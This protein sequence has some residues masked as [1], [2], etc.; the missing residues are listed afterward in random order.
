MSN[1]QTTRP[2]RKR[3]RWIAL[4]TLGVAGAIGGWY[5]VRHNNTAD[6]QTQLAAAAKAAQAGA[7]SASDYDRRV[8][9]YV[10]DNDPVSREDLGN[11]LI[12]RRGPE[13]L[14]ALIN[15]RIIETAAKERGVDAT[16]AEIETAL[17]ESITSLNVNR[18]R[19]VKE[20]LRTYRKSLFEWKEDVLRTKI[21]LSKMV[22]DRI[23]VSE[24]EMKLAFEALY[25][26]K[27]DCR[28]IIYPLSDREKAENEYARLRD[29][30]DAFSV[31]AKSQAT[32]PLASVSGHVKPIGRN[33]LSNKTIE[34][35]IFKLKPGEL[36]QLITDPQ[37]KTITLVRCDGR[38]PADTTKHYEAVRADLLRDIT[39]RKVQAEAAKLAQDLHVK[40]AVQPASTEA[41][42]MRQMLLHPG[43][44]NQVFA[45]IFGNVSI[46]REDLGEYLIDR[47]GAEE[48]EMLVNRRIIDRACKEHNVTVTDAEVEAGFE[49]ELARFNSDP[50][51]AIDAAKFEKLLL[52]PYGKSLFEFK[53]DVIRPKLMMTK[54]CQ[55]KIQC[56]EADL[57][58]A[59]DAE[60][61]E[62]LNGRMILWTPDQ[63]KFAWANYAKIR[64]N[65][66]DFDAAAKLQANPT[67]A[68][69]GGRVTPAI[70]RNTTGNE[71]F[72][73][74]IFKLQPGE[75]TS[76]IKTPQGLVVFKLDERIPPAAAKFEELRIGL[77]PKVLERK[78]MVEIPKMF[79]DMRAR[80][81]PKLLLKDVNQPEDL[82]ASVEHDLGHVST[83][84]GTPPAH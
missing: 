47:N 26:E 61:G 14:D 70:G 3:W 10:N 31:A 5:A 23:I 18:E 69:S 64:D 67:L 55:D 80:A 17:A 34:E 15:K 40:A 82:K 83:P 44:A 48:L 77:T 4:G 20:V 78:T 72:E 79:A 60:Y 75:M 84:V 52:A 54:L 65:P 73:K 12:A 41:T 29:S 7:A 2:G 16:G 81:N 6:A 30:E 39:E 32:G 53:E 24:E 76:L 42:Q 62:K 36:T 59:F 37:S 51:K 22:R 13:K 35:A 46:T 43:P 74:E 66:A 27:V 56:T 8:V 21:L 63:E 9:A 11:F 49:T 71:E 28:I 50:K 33:T 38:I 45:T 57:H 58:M 19:F 1:D 25:G 68:A